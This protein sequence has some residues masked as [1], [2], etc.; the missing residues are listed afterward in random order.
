[1]KIGNPLSILSHIINF[2]ILIYI[3]I[4]SVNTTCFKSSELVISFIGLLISIFVN[5]IAVLEE[6]N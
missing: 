6:R 4:G 5:I 2:S 3:F 1:M